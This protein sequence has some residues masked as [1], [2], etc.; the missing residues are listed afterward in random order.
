MNFPESVIAC[1]NNKEYGKAVQYYIDNSQP[2]D[3]IV[4]HILAKAYSDCIDKSFDEAVEKFVSII[5][6]FDHSLALCKF[7]GPS[8]QRY[9][10]KFLIGLHMKGQASSRHTELLF[11]IFHQKEI[12]KEYFQEFI[13]ALR[14]SK[15]AYDALLSPSRKSG[16]NEAS[17]EFYENFSK[18]VESAINV[19]CRN[20]MMNEAY[21]I[22]S[23][24][25][26]TSSHISLLIESKK[27]YEEAAN[28]IFSLVVND[29]NSDEVSTK[30][31]LIK[32]GHMLLDVSES[33]V[34]RKTVIDAA[35]KQ[36]EK[37]YNCVG[38][39]ALMFVVHDYVR[40]FWNH[41]RSFFDFIIRVRELADI[42]EFDTHLLNL[43]IP[44][45]NSKFYG[46]PSVSSKL[47]IVE[48]LKDADYKYDHDYI[49]YISSSRNF[50]D[51]V[52]SVLEHQEK[53]SEIINYL[54]SI[55]ERTNQF[56]P[57][58]D[59]FYGRQEEETDMTDVKVME[60]SFKRKCEAISAEEWKDIFKFFV[61]YFDG[62]VISIDR[63]KFVVNKASET[64]DVVEI[65][66]YASTNPK[67]PL[68]ALKSLTGNIK[69]T[70]DSSYD[71]KV[72]ELQDI[73][74]E[75]HRL[76]TENIVIRPMNC[77][78]CNR[79]LKRPMILFLCGHH[80]HESCLKSSLSEPVC[81][82][83]NENEVNNQKNVVN[84]PLNDLRTLMFEGEH[85][86]SH[87][88]DSNNKVIEYMN[89]FFSGNLPVSDP[90]EVNS[91]LF[92]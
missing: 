37:D 68:S 85:D 59:W 27:Q 29:E 46:S 53:Y 7:I 90:V 41:P 77:D 19:L 89:D 88:Q 14:K 1:L 72:K 4:K 83:C 25:P 73:E 81:P 91:T 35:I 47:D 30:N 84:G 40:L 8:C 55:C 24:I 10:A 60:E 36:L 26:N 62:D 42:K 20:G 3:D 51:G 70:F 28:L 32:Y 6:Y 16:R 5:G 92:N 11:N 79:P 31:I 66:S 22:S 71:M 76:E 80:F 65:L 58:I 87:P 39:D 57:F 63:L 15:E 18:N 33:E 13:D 34:V 64:M 45:E 21:E 44:C 82:L 69:R 52:V 43:L 86:D 9:Q 75:I 67:I 17:K 56:K 23:V 78:H 48:V 2:I 12:K 49:L 61:K 38:D 50:W 74:D 54:I